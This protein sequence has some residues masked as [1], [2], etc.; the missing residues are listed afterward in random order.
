MRPEMGLIINGLPDFASHKRIVPSVP[1]DTSLL[2]SN[3]HTD[4]TRLLWP[5]QFAINC[6]SFTRH[7]ATIKSP[8][9]LANISLSKENPSDQ[10][11]LLC[12]GLGESI[13]LPSL[14]NTLI[15]LSSPPVANK[16]PSL[17]LAMLSIALSCSFLI[18]LILPSWPKTISPLS[19]EHAHLLFSSPTN[20]NILFRDPIDIQG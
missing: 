15:V 13:I 17:F 16:V 10:I 7:T 19:K 6:P 20:P 2:S 11:L 18:S 1:A 3:Q 5:T 8:P 12:K 9:A 4:K 14:S